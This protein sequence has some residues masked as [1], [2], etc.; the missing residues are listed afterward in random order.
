MKLDAPKSLR[1]RPTADRV[2]EALFSIIASRVPGSRVLDLFAG[3][4]ALGLEALS[5]GALKAVFVDRSVEAVTII[6]ANIQR[7]GV[8]EQVEVLQGGV[9]Q[10]VRRLAERESRFDLLFMDPPYRKGLIE[11]TMPHL[12][13][14]ADA[15]ALLIVEHPA[16]EL[17][18]ESSVQWLQ[19]DRRFYGDTAISFY[20]KEPPHTQ[21]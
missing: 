12:V 9:I 15:N 6:R 2:R 10:V 16:K 4:G 14:L 8:T 13:E 11:I 5:R 17:A 21:V 19:V 20:L 7:L 18:P 1:I 3:T